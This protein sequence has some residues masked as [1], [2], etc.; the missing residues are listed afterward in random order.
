MP[1]SYLAANAMINTNFT[2]DRITGGLNRY[3]RVP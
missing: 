2:I 1:T 3:G